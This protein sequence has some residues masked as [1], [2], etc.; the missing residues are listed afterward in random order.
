MYS[1]YRSEILSS[2]SSCNLKTS[3]TEGT[4]KKTAALSCS[5]FLDGPYSGL[6]LTCDRSLHFDHGLLVPK[7]GGPIVDDLERRVLFQAPFLHQVALQDVEPRLPILEHLLQSEPLR[8]RERDS[9]KW[10]RRS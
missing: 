7:D 9:W 8:G 3:L 5:F 10:K 6:Q 2:E 1:I 4:Q